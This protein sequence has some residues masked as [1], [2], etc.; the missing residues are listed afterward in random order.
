MCTNTGIDEWFPIQ[1]KG[2]SSGQVHIKSVWKPGAAGGAKA[3]KTAMPTPMGYGVPM[4]MQQPMMYQQPYVMG[5][6]AMQ[7]MVGQPMMM[8]P[9]MQQ[10][11]MAM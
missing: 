3:G 11:M 10:P 9:G 5:A 6:G 4:G 7:P 8:Q 2:K 1:Y